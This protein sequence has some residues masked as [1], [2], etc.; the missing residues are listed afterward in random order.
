MCALPRAAIHG[1]GWASRTWSVTP[2]A[3]G[4]KE[5]DTD[6]SGSHPIAISSAS[7]IPFHD[8]DQWKTSWLQ[9]R[10]KITCWTVSLLAMAFQACT[11]QGLNVATC[12]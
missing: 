4:N 11:A 6:V 8:S 5:K 7:E 12:V 3:G 9:C 2:A 10:A 1:N